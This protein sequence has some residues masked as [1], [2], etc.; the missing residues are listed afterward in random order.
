[1]AS[2]LGEAYARARHFLVEPPPDRPVNGRSSAANIEV[3]VLGLSARCG[4]TTVARG[5]ALWLEP[6]NVRD[7]D[8]HRARELAQRLDAL[9]LVA[10]SSTEPSLAEVAAQMLREEFPRLLLVANR[11]TDLSRWE[12]CTDLCVPQSRLGVALVGRGRQPIG[13]FGAALRQLAELVT[14]QRSS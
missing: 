11:V 10:G 6:Q 3:S 7:C 2:L 1:V 8:L 4:A 5:L 12:A 14:A 13:T 9:V